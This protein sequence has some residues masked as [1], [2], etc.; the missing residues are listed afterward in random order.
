M[1]CIYGDLLMKLLYAT[2]P[3][4]KVKGTADKTYKKYNA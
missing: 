1:A 3:Y 4:E 2:R